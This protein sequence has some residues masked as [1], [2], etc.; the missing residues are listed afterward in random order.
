MPAQHSESAAPT[1]GAVVGKRKTN[2]GRVGPYL[3]EQQADR[4]R[5]CYLQGWLQDHRGTFSDMLEQFLFEGAQKIEHEKNGGQPW[6]P[7]TAGAI[8]SVSQMN[9]EAGR[10]ANED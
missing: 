10:R 3:T 9:I 7:I 8:K 5:A 4:L 1:S 6:P 2:K